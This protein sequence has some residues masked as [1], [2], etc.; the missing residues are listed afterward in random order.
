MSN[1]KIKEFKSRLKYYKS[2]RNLG[3]ELV[4]LGLAEALV[5][6]AEVRLATRDN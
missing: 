6:E 1:L 5:D 4:K 3:H 2:F